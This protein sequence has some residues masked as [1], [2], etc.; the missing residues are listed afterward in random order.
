MSDLR[1]YFQGVD[2]DTGGGT[3]YVLAVNLRLSASGG[4]IEA[5]GQKTMAVSIP[6]VL[7]S[8]QTSIPVDTELPA[9]A[10][11]TDTFA[12]PT[13]PGVGAFNM[14]WNGATWARAPGTAAGGT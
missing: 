6:V 14:V 1:S 13:A 3:D 12:N 8:D 2:C 5:I 11:L 7:A 4:A 9:A 10:A